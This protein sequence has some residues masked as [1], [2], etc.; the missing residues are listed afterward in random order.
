MVDAVVAL[1]NRCP[2]RLKQ[3]DK[4]SV[5]CPECGHLLLLHSPERNCLGCEAIRQTLLQASGQEVDAR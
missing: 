5:A 4:L 2:I 3:G 1:S